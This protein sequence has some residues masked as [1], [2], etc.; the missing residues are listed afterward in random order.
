MRELIPLPEIPEV[1]AG[2][3]APSVDRMIRATVSRCMPM[4]QRR[5]EPSLGLWQGQACIRVSPK[6]W[7]SKQ[8]TGK[9]AW[10]HS[11]PGL[12]GSACTSGFPNNVQQAARSKIHGQ[13]VGKLRELRSTT[14]AVV[15]GWPP[16]NQQVVACDRVGTCQLGQ[17]LP[18]G[19][20]SSE[21]RPPPEGKSARY[22][23]EDRSRREERRLANCS[24]LARVT[25][26]IWCISLVN[27]SQG[28]AAP[29]YGR[30][31]WSH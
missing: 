20:R 7:T 24:G 11:T 12:G 15:P 29:L 13:Q 9:L 6:R 14:M 28:E 17:C 18:I 25:S 16:R 10:V 19:G 22:C 31:S 27:S 8:C 23:Q 5:H 1:I 26:R 4:R 30:M 21:S 3:H 2:G